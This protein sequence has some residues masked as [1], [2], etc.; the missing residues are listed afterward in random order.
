[1]YARRRQ[2]PGS[3]RCP[4]WGKGERF[5]ASIV[6]RAS[7]GRSKSARM[8]LAALA[9]EFTRHCPVIGTVSRGGVIELIIDDET[10]NWR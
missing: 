8:L 2:A 5:R 9:L 6:A 4:Q 1:M 3:W 10:L 7:I